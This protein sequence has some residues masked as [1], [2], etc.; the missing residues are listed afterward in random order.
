[1]V[2]H[3]VHRTQFCSAALYMYPERLSIRLQ[4]RRFR[5]FPFLKAE[6]DIPTRFGLSCSLLRSR[7]QIRIFRQ[8]FYRGKASRHPPFQGGYALY[9]SAAV[10]CAS[11]SNCRLLPQ[12]HSVLPKYWFFR[13]RSCRSARSAIRYKSLFQPV[14]LS[15]CNL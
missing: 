13:F 3:C 7:Q 2:V 9:I 4:V 1:M 5:R 10:L 15:T 14:L 12:R 6:L 11:R 8:C